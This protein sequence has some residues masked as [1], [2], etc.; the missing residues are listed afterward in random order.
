MNVLY[1]KE[2]LSFKK[3]KYYLE[4]IKTSEFGMGSTQIIYM[5]LSSHLI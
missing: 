3:G 1:R 2:H 5:I 4:E